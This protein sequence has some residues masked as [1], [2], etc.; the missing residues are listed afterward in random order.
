MKRRWSV[1][2]WSSL[3]TLIGMSWL[4]S[5]LGM[6]LTAL[7]GLGLAGMVIATVIAFIAMKRGIESK[8]P[9]VIILICAAPLG[10]D[11]TRV[12]PELP[13][14]IKYFGVS[15]VL[16]V[17]GNLATVATAIVLLLAGPPKPP[18]QPPIAPARVVD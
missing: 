4:A 3:G 12:L 18:R 11:M 17:V 15:I 13:F 5:S 1:L 9:A 10:I 2:F 16:V 14:F 7:L 6:H 8:A